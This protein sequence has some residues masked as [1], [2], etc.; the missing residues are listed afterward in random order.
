M[1]VTVRWCANGKWAVGS[2]MSVYVDLY[3]FLHIFPCLFMLIYASL[4]HVCA[5]WCVSMFVLVVLV[6]VC[7]CIYVHTDL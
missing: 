4:V 5:C 7:A 1:V 3:L 6:H 2:C